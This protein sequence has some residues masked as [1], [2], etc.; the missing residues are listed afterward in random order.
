MSPKQNNP[1]FPDPDR[2]PLHDAPAQPDSADVPASDGH[3]RDEP[4]DPAQERP[5][6]S[7][8]QALDDER[9]DRP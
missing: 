4:A 9:N 7:P 3:A 6:R 2:E 5:L 8:G 1:D